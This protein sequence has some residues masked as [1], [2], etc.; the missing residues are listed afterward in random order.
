LAAALEQLGG[1]VPVD[2]STVAMPSAQPADE[3]LHKVQSVLLTW[4]GPFGALPPHLRLPCCD[5]PLQERCIQVLRGS[6]E[7]QQLFARISGQADRMRRDLFMSSWSVA[8]ELSDE[9]GGGA[10]EARRVH[11]HM[12]C[13]FS[14]RSRVNRAALKFADCAPHLSRPVFCNGRGRGRHVHSN[15]GQGHYYC[16]APK[17]S[18]I[19]CA[20][21]VNVTDSGPVRP[22]WI[23][24]LYAEQKMYPDVAVSEAIKSR[25]DTIRTVAFIRA[26]EQL[27][28][29]QQLQH[30]MD[31]VASAER[32]ARR[33]RV[34][35]PLIE[36]DF[37]GQFDIVL[38]RRK[39]L[40]LTGPSGTGKTEYVKSLASDPVIVTRI[41]GHFRAAQERPALCPVTAGGTDLLE[42]T[43]N[44][45]AASLPDVRSLDPLRHGWLL[46]DEAVPQLV[47]CNKRLFQG[48]SGHVDM[49]ASSTNCHAFRVSTWGVRIVLTANDWL[50]RVSSLPPA[51][52]DW[53]TQNSFVVQVQEQLW[54]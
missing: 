6:P 32:P 18:T 31:R 10:T 23:L 25:R 14:T 43:C 37:L 33:P 28:A 24:A 40:V 51:D 12:F 54:R 38:F 44:G 29:E 27:H 15:Q 46:L 45:G 42:L 9:H 47:T 26:C 53:L 20:S 19:L 21:S 5:R 3:V 39:F 34:M 11:L 30:L 52:V 7:M 49:A 8:L 22:Q 35:V 4:N 2:E 41:R 36:N 48:K 16:T 17:T 13:V 50:D 1:V